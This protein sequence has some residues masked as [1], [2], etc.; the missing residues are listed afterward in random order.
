[1]SK[2]VTGMAMAAIIGSMPMQVAAQRLAKPSGTQKLQEATMNDVPHCARK[3][4]TISIVDGDDS[5]G[6][7]QYNLAPPQ[8][9]LKVLVQ[10]SGCF[11]I[12]DRGSG[13]QAAQR[14]RDIGGD[15]GL[16]RGS[17]VGQGQI[18][19]ADYV[20]Q[21][22]VQGANSN[23]SGSGVAAGLG[24]LIGGPIGGIVGGVRSRK[25]EAN[26]VLSITNVRTTETL[27]TEDGY[28]AKN[29]LSFGG[30]GGVFGGVA[31]GGVIGGGYD[32]TDIGRIVTLAFIQAYAKLVND[33]GYV[34]P[35]DTGTAE[36]APAKTFTAQGPLAL[37]SA[38][39]ATGRVL[40]TLP[41]GA[42]VYPTGN[43]NGLWWE[44]ADENDNVGWVLN[45]K[46]APS[47]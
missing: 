27:A 28:A 46:L 2:I 31:G 26:V 14:E 7:T 17:N 13:L 34:T 35:G 16:Q 43:K 45:T 29:S 24:G 33:L 44:V 18:K 36:A 5:R 30:G 6:W 12:V 23:A 21:A 15:L 3:H 41:A 20:L 19:A 1:M 32:N 8:K 40:R 22:E 4:G 39:S 47:R 25:M 10:R 11:N 42:I 38:A 9:L 37:R